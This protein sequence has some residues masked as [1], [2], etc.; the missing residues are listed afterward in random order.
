MKLV[1]LLHNLQQDITN[2]RSLSWMS[3]Y[4][5]SPVGTALIKLRKTPPEAWSLSWGSCMSHMLLTLYLDLISGGSVI[6]SM[7]VK[8]GT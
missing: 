3:E 8:T 5:N 7:L 6:G 2:P 1:K 4:Y